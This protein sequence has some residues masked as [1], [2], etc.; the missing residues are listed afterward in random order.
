MMKKNNICASCGGKL[1]QKK[2]KYDQHWGDDIVIFEDVPARVCLACGEIWLNSKV[3]RAM[4]RI[5]KQGKKPNKKMSVPVWSL[6]G[7][8][9]A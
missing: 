5:L 3:I 4:E 8:R 2:I 1:I 7:L 6:S 9:A